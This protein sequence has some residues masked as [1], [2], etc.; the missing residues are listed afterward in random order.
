MPSRELHGTAG[1]RELRA[2]LCSPER[3]EREHVTRSEALKS[4][5]PPALTP[6][7]SGE[8][9]ANEWIEIVGGDR[10]LNRVED[11]SRGRDNESD[12]NLQNEKNLE[13]C[14]KLNILYI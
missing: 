6:G 13:L 10:S 2:H 3:T 1:P 9:E 5:R 8:T 4:K 11:Y 14:V 12:L 7:N